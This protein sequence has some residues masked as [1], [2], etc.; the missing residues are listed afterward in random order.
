MSLNQKTTNKI[1]G[2]LFTI[3]G[4]YFF[5]KNELYKISIL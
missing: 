3:E 1:C 2:S 4:C 5:Y